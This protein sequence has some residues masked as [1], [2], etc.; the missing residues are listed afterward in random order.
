MPT[1]MITRGQ[2]RKSALPSTMPEAVEGQDEARQHDG[3]PDHD[4]WRDPQV[5]GRLSGLNAGSIVCL[6]SITYGRT[7]PSGSR[8][9]ANPGPDRRMTV[10]FGLESP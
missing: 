2:K 10:S 3:E 9:S 5:R 6:R 1:A 7:G 8:E 4:A